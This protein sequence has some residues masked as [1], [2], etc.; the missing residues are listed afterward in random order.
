MHHVAGLMCIA[1][2]PCELYAG[3]MIAQS[4]RLPFSVPIIL[5]I[6][7]LIVAEQ[8]SR[9]VAEEG[10]LRQI[11]SLYDRQHEQGEQE[12]SAYLKRIDWKFRSTLNDQSVL[13][14]QLVGAEKSKVKQLLG[15]PDH[16]WTL[17]PEMDCWSYETTSPPG[18]GDRLRFSWKQ[19]DIHF[20]HGVAI[21]AYL[22]PVSCC[23]R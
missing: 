7:L 11:K 4:L 19:F 9:S 14:N 15:H 17:S 2:I 6:G 13:I 22:R 3:L 20:R 10:T 8:G 16:T 23:C 21:S 5:L 1:R 12:Y 18:P